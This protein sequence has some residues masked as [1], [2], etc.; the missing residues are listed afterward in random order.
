MEGFD[1][2][3]QQLL[4]CYP[5]LTAQRLWEELRNRGCTGSY[6]TVWRRLTELRPASSKPPVIRFETSAGAH[7]VKLCAMLSKDSRWRV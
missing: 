3:I 1:P 2:I 5:D 7:Y 6:P 4:E